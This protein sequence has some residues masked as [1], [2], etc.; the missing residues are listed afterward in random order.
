MEDSR[1]V[2]VDDKKDCIIMEVD[3]RKSKNDLEVV[4]SNPIQS[5]MEELKTI[6]TQTFSRISTIR[7]SIVKCAQTLLTCSSI[8]C[9]KLSPLAFLESHCKQKRVKSLKQ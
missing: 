2:W 6:D 5:R 7:M 9:S 8:R 1:V 4:Q 3:G